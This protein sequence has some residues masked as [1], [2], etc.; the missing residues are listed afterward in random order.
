M[1][2]P[3]PAKSTREDQAEPLDAYVSEVIRKTF[4]GDVASGD[5]SVP[6]I[7][8]N[9][10]DLAVRL[11][12][13]HSLDRLRDVESDRT[14]LD[15][16]LWSLVGG[17]IGFATNVITGNQ[18]VSAAGYVFISMLGITLVG[19]ILIRLRLG[20]RLKDARERVQK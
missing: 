20:R 14:L 11:V 6:I 13:Q 2:Q 10:E 4:G 17:V 3:E 5:S 15:S 19:V 7:M 1:V 8:P 18:S 16:I 12:S 9:R